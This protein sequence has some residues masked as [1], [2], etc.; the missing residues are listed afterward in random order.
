MKCEVI[1]YYLQQGGFE[2]AAAR[3][4][5]YLCYGQILNMIQ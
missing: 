5:N 3:L 2:T 4:L 1:S